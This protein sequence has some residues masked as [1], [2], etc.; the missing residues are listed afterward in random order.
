MRPLFA[1]VMVLALTGA[2]CQHRSEAP[3]GDANPI[4]FIPCTPSLTDT[5]V[6]WEA[7]PEDPKAWDELG[8]VTLPTLARQSLTCEARRQA[9][10]DFIQSLKRRGVYRG[11][12]E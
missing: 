2:S 7:D 12:E 4:C 1:I 9:C 8:D 10:A 6:R 11:A 5:G 3:V